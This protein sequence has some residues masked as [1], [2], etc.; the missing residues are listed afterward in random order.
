M[1]IKFAAKVFTRDVMSRH[2]S[3]P[4]FQALMNVIEQKE[5][6]NRELADQVAH[7]MKEWAQDHGA[8]HF[9]HWFQPQRGVTAEKHDAFLTLEDGRPI[10]RFSGGQLIQSE[11][12]ASSFPSGGMRSTFEAR[13]YTAWDPTSP[14]FIMNGSKSATLVIPSVYMSYN[15]EVLDLKT[16]L[17][18]SLGQVEK[19]AYR[20]LKL[21]GNRTARQVKVTVGPEQEYFLVDKS[22]FQDRLDLLLTGR[23]L[24]GAPSA[25]QQ[26]FEDHYFGSIRPRVLSFMEDVEKILIDRGIPFKTRHNEVAPN[27]YELA[28][29][30]VEANL[31]VD[32]NL[33]TM[34]IM[35]QVADEHN[36]TV[37]LH[38]KPFAGMNGS[39]KHLNWSMM[40][41]DGN[42]LLEPGEAPKR[43]VQF[44]AF[45]S[46][47]MLGVFKYSG[48]LRA[49]VADA[50]N[51]HRLGANE[52]PPPIMSVFIG[53][54]IA[55]V[56]DAIAGGKDI[57]DLHEASLDLKVRHLPGVTLDTTDRNRTSP[58]AFT[59]NKFE[60]R[61]VGSSQNTS[62]STTALNLM[63]AAGLEMM[64]DRITAYQEKFEDVKDAALAAIRDTLNE[65]ENIRFDGNNY[66]D[67]W[68]AEAKKRNLPAARNTPEALGTYL[69]PEVIELYEKYET[70]TSHEIHARVEVRREQYVK[71]KMLELNVLAE[72]ART[73]VRPALIKHLQSMA[74]SAAVLSP[75]GK[76]R[77]LL[78]KNIGQLE[79]LFERFESGLNAIDEVFAKADAMV[80]RD[81]AGCADY[82]G[83]AG[84]AT[85]EE[86]RQVCNAIE[87][88]VED[89]IWALPK[90]ST[91]LHKM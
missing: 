54:Y 63:V 29:T 16:P 32:Q 79:N 81:L 11:P 45:L 71:I 87:L 2:L 49:S 34:E 37:L 25:K 43:N 18:R 73:Q 39:G 41:S 61:A 22:I 35:R 15:G 23:T 24:L 65:V 8:T 89:A 83:N 57:A 1:H 13:G 72:I 82:L 90:Y 67:D 14:A 52:A 3:K 68:H 56:L 30:F 5:K 47:F 58:V 48:L 20:M 10:E 42:N 44:L 76:G 85:L 38:E 88:E 53:G 17:L 36:L 80:H 33:Q 6:L 26:Q 55:A 7:A 77:K 40:D 59:G 74:S 50:G 91:I 75:G 60:F 64:I 28:P 12:D 21:F 46:A 66:S 31:A 69:Q 27:Q 9:T 84:C 19:Q 70:L 78:E 62:E 86:M 4:A 51:D